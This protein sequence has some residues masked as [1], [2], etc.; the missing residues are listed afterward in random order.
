MHHRPRIGPC[1]QHR[2][3]HE[4][5]LGWLITRHMRKIRRELRYPR[6]IKPAQAG[7]GRRHQISIAQPHTDIAR[8]PHRIAARKKR[9]TE[10][11]K[12]RAQ[13]SLIHGRTPS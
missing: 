8:G 12:L 9:G 13:R 6:G 1:G 4:D 11:G 7:I 10:R 2:T 5:F 3:M